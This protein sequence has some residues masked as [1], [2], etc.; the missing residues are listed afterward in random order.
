MDGME[1]QQQAG[2]QTQSKQ[3]DELKTLADR[4]MQQEQVLQQ[5]GKEAADMQACVLKR[6][7]T[8]EQSLQHD[9]QLE[10]DQQAQFAARL[11]MEQSAAKL[12]HTYSIYE[13]M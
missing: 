10:Q 2:A 7:G 4:Q 11:E 13:Y 6:I 5:L 8:H 3:Q 12:R 1:T 9:H